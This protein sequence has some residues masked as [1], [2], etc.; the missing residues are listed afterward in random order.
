MILIFII[1]VLNIMIF[2]IMTFNIQ[3]LIIL[4]LS[5]QTLNILTPSLMTLSILTLGITPAY[6]RITTLD[7]VCCYAGCK[8]HTRWRTYPGEK[9]VTFSLC[10]KNLVV[11][12]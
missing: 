1:M 8:H 10:K 3:T 4:T 6:I 7:T 9:R 12:K 2:S 11:K 5:I